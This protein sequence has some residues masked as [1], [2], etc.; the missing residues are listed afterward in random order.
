LWWAAVLLPAAQL[1]GKSWRE[2]ELRDRGAVKKMAQ[3]D[4]QS[5]SA[6]C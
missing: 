1:Y 4:L 5:L 6:Q 3:S 2:N